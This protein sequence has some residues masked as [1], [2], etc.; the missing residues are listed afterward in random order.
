MIPGGYL[1]REGRPTERETLISRL[2]DRPIRNSPKYFR[3][4]MQ[5]IATVMSYDHASDTDVLALCGSAA[6]LH[7]SDIP[8]EAPVAGVQI[9]RVNGE[10]VVN[11]SNSEQDLADINLVVAG[12][13]EGICMVEGGAN[14]ANEE[15]MI[16]A[17]DLAFAEIQKIIGAIEE[18]R[19]K[20][21][22]IK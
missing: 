16:E 1:K 21:V 9:C 3:R 20:A 18:L 13:R 19:E 11:P 6:A 14:E 7:V 5:V 8:M 4:E 22:W 12:S 10:F 2:I 17:M 15:A